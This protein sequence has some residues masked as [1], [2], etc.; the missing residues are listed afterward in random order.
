MQTSILYPCAWPSVCILMTS[1]A[2]YLAQ[3]AIRVVDDLEKEIV[4]SEPA[5]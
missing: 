2:R 3:A 5:I 4:L 1:L